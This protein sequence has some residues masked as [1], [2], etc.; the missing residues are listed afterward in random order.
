MKPAARKAL[1]LAVPYAVF[2]LLLALVELAVRASAGRLDPLEVFVSA[3]QRAQ[4]DDARA[5]RIFEFDPL[6]FW[7][8]KP[9]LRDVIW[10]HT[11]V[12]TSAERLRY[13]R[14]LGPKPRGTFRVLCAGDSVTFGF[15]VPQIALKRPQDRPPDWLPYPA[16]VEKALRAANPGRAVEVA[17]LAV[18]GYSTH[19]GLAWMRR[20]LRALA[21]DLVT[22]LYGWND[23]GLRAEPDAA[24]MRTDAWSVFA[25]GLLARSQALLRLWSALHAR[26]GGG[27]VGPVRGVPRVDRD[28]YVANV[29]AMT[30]VA[31]AAG[32]AVVVI[33][34]V[35]RDRVEYP[36]EGDWIAERRTALRAAM[37]AAG[38]P[39]LE[40]PEL[41]EASWPG[42]EPLFLEHIHPNQKGHRL[43]AERLLAFLGARAL[44]G[45]LRVP[46][47][48]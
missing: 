36:P 27:S 13:D 29:R 8:L 38:V 33:G 24:A 1:F 16:R 48:S 37:E 6:L 14:A 35:Y 22:V 45:G 11:P 3:P 7:R 19:Q 4:F 44:L 39:Y 34:P 12:T 32:A 17:P 18:P 42:N 26:G 25:R 23:I 28:G 41:T 46:E 15:G 40:V 5:V 43:L 10:E 2:A 20:D 47:P 31:R 30:E 21:P 9:G